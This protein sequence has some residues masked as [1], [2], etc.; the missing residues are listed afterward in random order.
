[1]KTYTYTYDMVY[2]IKFEVTD[3]FTKSMAQDFLN[4]FSWEIPYDKDANPIDEYMRKLAMECLRQ[5]TMNEHNTFG[6]ISD[7]EGLEGYPKL[8][9]SLGIKLVY[10]EGLEYDEEDISVKVTDS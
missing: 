2:E 1:M 5:A 9:G 4:F 6:V 7:F 3:Q 8:D 10:A